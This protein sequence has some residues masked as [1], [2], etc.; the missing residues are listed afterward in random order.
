MEQVFRNY[1]IEW[2]NIYNMDEMDF[3]ISSMQAGYIV[4]DNTM[5]SQFQVQ[6]SH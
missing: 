2:K 3:S 5:Q 4:V 1:K 6:P